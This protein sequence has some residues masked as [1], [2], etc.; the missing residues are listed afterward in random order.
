MCALRALY[1]QILRSGLGNVLVPTHSGAAEFAVA[2][3]WPPSRLQWGVSYT[4]KRGVLRN[5]C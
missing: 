1:Q 5:Q 3:R 4:S 2:V